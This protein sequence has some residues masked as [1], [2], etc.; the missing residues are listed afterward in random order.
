M[1]IKKM[2]DDVYEIQNFLTK[3]ELLGVYQ[4]INELKEE[5]WF[6]EGAPEFWSG[7]NILFKEKKILCEINNKMKNLFS[8]FQYYPGQTI[9]QRYKKGDFIASHKDQWRTDID[10]YIGYGLCLYFNDDYE[11]GELE[12]PELGIIVKPKSNSLYIHGGNIVHGSLP[13]LNDKVRYFS[14]AFVHGTNENPTVL[15]EDL[16]K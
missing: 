2:H 4:I 12:Y 6:A 5:D 9:L 8:S 11:G 3:E 15:R 1:N 10:Y 16:F 7:K 14:T 13:V